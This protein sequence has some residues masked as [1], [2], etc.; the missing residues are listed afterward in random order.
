MKLY[1]RAINI[2]LKKVKK[3]S[4]IGYYLYE[5]DFFEADIKNM[6]DNERRYWEKER[7]I[8]LYFQ[9]NNNQQCKSN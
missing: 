5:L 7:Y 6:E 9:K 4:K 1:I 2:Y 8:R 3:R